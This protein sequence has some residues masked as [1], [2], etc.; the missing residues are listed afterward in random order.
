PVTVHRLA[1]AVTVEVRG[2]DDDLVRDLRV[3]PRHVSEDVGRADVALAKRE[4]RME[5][6]G[7]GE[8]R[9]RLARA[10]RG[11]QR[12]GA[13]SAAGDEL[14]QRVGVEGHPQERV[15]LL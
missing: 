14:A 12:R 4:P 15:R 5:S 7:D 3:A 9:Q 2:E 13:A 10:S 1:V 6:G 8:A 11:D